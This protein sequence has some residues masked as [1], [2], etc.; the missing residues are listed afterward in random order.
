[1]SGNVKIGLLKVLLFNKFRVIV[2]PPVGVYTDNSGPMCIDDGDGTFVMKREDFLF[3]CKESDIRYFSV[4]AKDGTQTEYS[5]LTGAKTLSSKASKEKVIV[6]KG[7]YVTLG[8]SASAQEITPED[9]GEKVKEET[10]LPDLPVDVQEEVS[11]VVDQVASVEAINTGDPTP[12]GDEIA[13]APKGLD[14]R[15]EVIG[16]DDQLAAAIEK[17]DRGDPGPNILL[18][19]I[20]GP[21]DMT[22]MY[23]CANPVFVLH[24]GD[25]G[26]R[27]LDWGGRLR[28]GTSLE[29]LIQIMRSE[30]PEEPPDIRSSLRMPPILKF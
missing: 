28:L 5:A 2:N 30:P 16:G 24:D 26:T 6:P 3:F 1:M 20:L 12:I 7:E 8:E 13:L 15:T 9:V 10:I 23:G 29:R 25:G 18:S 22:E 4:V 19:Q 17:F 21:D 14:F 27:E 11:P